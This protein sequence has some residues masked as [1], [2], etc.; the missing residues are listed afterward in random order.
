M[1]DVLQIDGSGPS[2]A[3]GNFQ[4]R[5]ELPPDYRGI[6][7]HGDGFERLIAE[8]SGELETESR[9]GL[10]DTVIWS[11]EMIGDLI[12]ADRISLIELGR[13]VDGCGVVYSHCNQQ[14]ELEP[15]AS[16]VPIR[17]LCGE[18]R[19]GTAHVITTPTSLPRSASDD[20]S[21]LQ[22]SGIESCLAAPLGRAA[23]PDFA[24]LCESRLRNCGWAVDTLKRVTLAGRMIANAV[25]RCR[26]DQTIT[27]LRGRLVEAQECER[28]R[29]ARELH[30]DVSQR[31]AHLCL[32]LVRLKDEYEN[33]AIDIGEVAND[34]ANRTRVLSSDIGRIC[35]ELYPS[36]LEH[37]DLSAAIG[38]LC[39][40][41]TNRHTL[42]VEFQDRL[43]RRK[44]PAETTFSLYRIA[45]EALRNV[46][47][48]S[49]ARSAVIVLR[50]SRR[51]IEMLI[52]DT[53]CGFDPDTAASGDG[54]GLNSMRDRLQ[55]IGGHLL[56]ETI[57]DLGTRLEI[58]V[59]A[60]RHS[61]GRGG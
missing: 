7:V 35:R 51:G 43:G 50:S 37:A 59:P 8:L 29:I 44:V 47:K 30:D 17:W 61:A 11:L 48:H 19:Q 22:A 9:E 16:V 13:D 34:L 20:R 14:T 45:Q 56:I 2:M 55:L 38:G 58:W 40:D 36:R 49:G 5:L 39:R 12:G 25:R 46:V 26:A 15:I 57:P 41:F 31:M 24:L 60:P 18:L 23:T 33:G 10:S 21:F 52:T 28:R 42:D 4:M 53:G 1:K 27:E 3:S 32:D 6:Q 54:L